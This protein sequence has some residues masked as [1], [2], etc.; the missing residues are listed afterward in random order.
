MNLVPS[1][2]IDL[3]MLLKTESIVTFFQPILSVRQCAIIGYEALSRGIDPC[4]KD[5]LPPKPLFQ[6]AAENN[7]LVDLD[8]LCRRKALEIYSLIAVNQDH[9]LLF[10]NLDT[11]ILDH[12]TT[13]SCPLSDMIKECGI[14]PS[15]IVIEIIESNVYDIRSLKNFIRYYKK[16][17]VGIALD[18]VGIGHSNLDRIFH[19]HPDI[20]KI[21]RLLIKDI[22]QDSY[23]QE[24]FKSLVHMARKLGCLVVAEGIETK[25]EALASLEFGADMLQ[26]YYFSHPQPPADCHPPSIEENV[27]HI[28]TLFRTKK[29]QNIE[30]NCQQRNDNIQILQTA[31]FTLRK[32]SPDSFEEHLRKI[33]AEHPSIQYLYILDRT[34]IQITDTIGTPGVYEEQRNRIF[35]A[36][37]QG[38]NQSL[39]NYCMFIQAGMSQYI[40]EP[41]MSLATGRYCVTYSMRFT[42][43]NGNPYIFCADFD[44]PT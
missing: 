33:I 1:S 27:N 11:A 8:R 15:S 26:G 36:A 23:K 9:P 44:I 34:G 12:V 19:V 41:Y 29:F 14:P 2:F 30:L 37:R 18:D 5:L 42:A 43:G 17:G 3:K 28:A 20:I 13:D 39:K 10:L 24:L 40:T 38:A 25:A 16:L 7:K 31:L 35:H 6:L 22:D 21:D 4:T 32:S